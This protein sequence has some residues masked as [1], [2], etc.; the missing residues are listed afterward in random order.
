MICTLPN[1]LKTI[2]DL[3][4][5]VEV[6]A[7][8]GTDHGLLPIYLIQNKKASKVYA[9]DIA[10]MPLNKAKENI[11]KYGLKEYIYPILSDGLQSIPKEVEVVVIA[12]MGGHLIASIIHQR[13]I[14]YPTLIVQANSHVEILRKELLYSSYEIV[15]EKLIFEKGKYYEII[16]AKWSS[17]KLNYNDLELKYGPILL[18]NK[19]DIFMQR[20]KNQLKQY[21]NI[22][23][24]LNA[25]SKDYSAIKEKILEIKKIMS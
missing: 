12:G 2:A 13:L 22:F 8:I 18:K 17:K 10:I 19:D 7:D 1:R 24:E 9:S 6:V 25:H 21:E 11:D 23:K 20:C 3:I 15:E 5:K 14:N 4:K 16:K